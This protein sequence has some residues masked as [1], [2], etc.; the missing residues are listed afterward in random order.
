MPRTPVYNPEDEYYSQQEAAKTEKRKLGTGEPV[1]L[2][3][4]TGIGRYEL[5]DKTFDSK[6][7][8]RQF[9][10][11]NYHGTPIKTLTQSEALAEAR[12]QQARSEKITKMK[13]RA[14]SGVK[15]GARG[16]ATATETI[17]RKAI[18]A[19]RQAVSTAS[20]IHEKRQERLEE[21]EEKRIEQES[22][23]LA[24]ERIAF[25]RARIAQARK[26]IQKNQP[27]K[28]LPPVGG[29]YLN[30]WTSPKRMTMGAPTQPR[31]VINPPSSPIAKKLWGPSEATKIR[32]VPWS[33]ARQT[34]NI[35]PPNIW[36]R[37]P[38]V[39]VP[40]RSKKQKPHKSK[41]RRK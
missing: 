7:E 20:D 28:P 5:V 25:E 33:P 18:S 14:I 10:D 36:Q 8:A 34:I 9:A 31:H 6:I 15:A 3:I 23:A 38:S 24:K 2:Y 11:E 19:T 37:P 17:G 12:R 16:I 4:N 22:R 30:I 39:R 41:K 13:E 29:S 1:L 27:T 40:V 21:I 32:S 26:Q 35:N